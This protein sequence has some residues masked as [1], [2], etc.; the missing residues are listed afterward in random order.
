MD[1]MMQEI[2]KYANGTHLEVVWNYGEC[3]LSGNIDTIYETN[4][5]LDEEEEGYKEFYACAFRVNNIIVNKKRKAFEPD[6][7]IEISIE[8][9]PTQIM[10]QDGTVIWKTLRERHANT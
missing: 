4:N 3:V 5:G 2:C 7:L 8:N 9:Q 1:E 10:L 6:T